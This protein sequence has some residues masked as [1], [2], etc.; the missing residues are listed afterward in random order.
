MI[1]T[2]LSGLSLGSSDPLALERQRPVGADDVTPCIYMSST[3]TCGRDFT[4]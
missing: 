3:D 1:A 4:S 2:V